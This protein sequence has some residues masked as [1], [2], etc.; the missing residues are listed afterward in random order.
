[1][2]TNIPGV[3][4]YDKITEQFCTD[5]KRAFNDT[6]DHIV[7]GGLRKMGTAMR[8]GMVLVMSLWDDHDAKML[9]LDSNYPP[10]GNSSTPGVA[11]GPCATTS[12]VPSETQ[13]QYPAATVKFSNIKFGAIGSTTGFL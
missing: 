4:N 7:K 10:T 13:N 2:Q 5:T 11:R 12:G 9:W 8:N 6:N 1:M 3:Q